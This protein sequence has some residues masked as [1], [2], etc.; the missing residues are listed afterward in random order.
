M[1]LLPES[2]AGRLMRLVAAHPGAIRQED[3]SAGR[4]AA[5]RT[6]SDETGVFTA[7]LKAAACLLFESASA[8]SAL[9]R[10]LHTDATG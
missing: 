10:T 6:R 4:G 7:T 9:T 3:L 1:T 5:A 8:R 2:A